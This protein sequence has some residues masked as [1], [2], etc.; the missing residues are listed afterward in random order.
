M[1]KRRYFELRTLDEKAFFG[2]Y[3]VEKELGDGRTKATEQKQDSEKGNGKGGN[4]DD[5]MTDAQKRYLFRLLADQGIE[6]DKAYD[7][8][9]NLFQVE[10]LKDVPKSE[11]SRAIENLL[12]K[13]G[14]KNGSS[15]K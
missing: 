2:F 3:L 12:E 13:G 1:E 6:G 14:A 10:V 8:L 9:K 5:L 4:N 15:F 7:Y 11:A